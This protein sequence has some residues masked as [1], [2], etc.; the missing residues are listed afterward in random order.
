MERTAAAIV[1]S[2]FQ[3]GMAMEINVN[4]MANLW[5]WSSMDLVSL[6]SNPPFWK[7]VVSFD[8][9]VQK[10]EPWGNYCF[11][12]VCVQPRSPPR[13]RTVWNDEM[14]ATR[15]KVQIFPKLWPGVIM[16]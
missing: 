13:K 1:F 2:Q 5:L 10:P 14:P 11:V 6:Y 7:Q 12:R 4:L 16:P 9:P 15:H 8:A 3:T